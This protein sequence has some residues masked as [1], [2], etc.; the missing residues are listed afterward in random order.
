MER[1]RA[2]YNSSLVRYHHESARV[3]ER[4]EALDDRFIQIVSGPTQIFVRLRVLHARQQRA[5]D[6]LT[7]PIDD[8][9]DLESQVENLEEY[10]DHVYAQI[11]PDLD[12][13]EYEQLIAED[14]R[15]QDLLSQNSAKSANISLRQEK[16]RQSL[17][18]PKSVHAIAEI[19]RSLFVP[20]LSSD[21]RERRSDPTLF[22]NPEQIAEITREIAAIEDM[23]RANDLARHRDE[24]SHSQK[25]ARITELM[26]QISEVEKWES[27]VAEMAFE[28]RTLNSDLDDLHEQRRML[29]DRSSRSKTRLPSALVERKREKIE[30]RQLRIGQRREMVKEGHAAWEKGI[31]TYRIRLA[32]IEKLY[33]EVS[34][35]STQAQSTEDL[36]LRL[37]EELYGKRNYIQTGEA[38]QKKITEL[39]RSLALISVGSESKEEEE[40]VPS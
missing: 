35:R 5:V 6:I 29:E 2:R 17:L 31:A 1:Q 14:Q 20:V 19:D 18:M 12:R 11:G 25:L 30:S 22:K 37:S 10:V 24:E 26:P 21:D 38:P 7:E 16:C 4:R 39:K 15:L 34:K 32:E 3:Q 27:L 40:D 13:A 23:A 28:V 36:S 9:S 33:L 8:L